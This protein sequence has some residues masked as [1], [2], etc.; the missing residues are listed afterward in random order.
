MTTAA[1]SAV[2]ERSVRI[3]D[4]FNDLAYQLRAVEFDAKGHPDKKKLTF[5]LGDA[6]LIAVNHFKS[7]PFLSDDI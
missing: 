6:F 2:K 4:A 5:D 1:A 7:V 3:H